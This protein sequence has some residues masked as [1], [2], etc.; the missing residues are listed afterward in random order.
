[1]IKTYSVIIPTTSNAIKYS[2]L[3]TSLG[4]ETTGAWI[5]PHTMRRHGH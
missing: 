2:I 1:M 4:L 5:I 3:F